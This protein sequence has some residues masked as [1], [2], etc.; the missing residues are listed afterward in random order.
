MAYIHGLPMY[1]QPVQRAPVARKGPTCFT[2]H[3]S[4]LQELKVHWAYSALA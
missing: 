3:I 1:Q 4:H 2:E